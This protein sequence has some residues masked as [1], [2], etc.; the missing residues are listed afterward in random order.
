MWAMRCSML[1]CLIGEANS[2]A[3]SVFQSS[4]NGRERQSNDE[5]LIYAN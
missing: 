2:M 1:L 3:S 5:S 4:E